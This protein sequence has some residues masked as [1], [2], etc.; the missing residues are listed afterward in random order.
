MPKLTLILNH[1]P[2]IPGQITIYYVSY[3]LIFVNL[4]TPQNLHRGQ[5]LLTSEEKERIWPA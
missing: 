5:N 2:P 3:L 4:N 1:E